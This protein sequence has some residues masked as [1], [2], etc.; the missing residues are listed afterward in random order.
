[1]PGEYIHHFVAVWQS[2]KQDGSGFGIFGEIGPIIG[3]A[4]CNADGLV[5]FRD[6]CI[7]TEEWLEEENP[8][9]ADLIDDNKINEQDLAEFCHQWLTSGYE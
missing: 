2:D 4:D 5:D 9:I 1:M 7:L 6:Y 3:S 8:L